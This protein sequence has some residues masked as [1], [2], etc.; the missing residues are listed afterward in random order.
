LKEIS[1]SGGN[2]LFNQTDYKLRALTEVLAAY[3]TVRFVLFGDDGEQDPEIYAKLQTTFPDQIEA[4]WI[5][6]VHPN[7][8]RATFPAQGDTAELLASPVIAPDVT[9]E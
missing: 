3:P 4:V 5:R 9:Q 8:G 6:R 2:S 1:E 7:P